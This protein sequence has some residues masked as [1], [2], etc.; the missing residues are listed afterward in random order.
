MDFFFCVLIAATPCL[1]FSLVMPHASGGVIIFVRQGLSLSELSTSSLISLDPYSDCVGVNISLNKSSSLSFL[2]VYV[3]P[4]RSSPTDSRTNSFS[5]STISSSR[6]FFIL[7]DFNCHHLL[8][9]SKSTFDPREKE[10]FEWIISSDLLPLNDPDVSTLLHY[11]SGSRSSPDIFFV[12]SSLAL[13]CSRE[14]LQDLASD[15]LPIL[16]RVPPSP[17]FCPN[18]RPPS[19]NFQKAR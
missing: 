9:D 1:A 6:N 5:P 15:H 11:S 12:P 16:L 19:S 13:S 8:W 3:P 4:N 10:L 17:I 2:N 14:V 18:E 7:G